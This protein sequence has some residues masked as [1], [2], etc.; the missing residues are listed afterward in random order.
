MWDRNKFGHSSQFLAGP[1]HSE[2]EKKYYE[3]N[4]QNLRQYKKYEENAKK[5]TQYF[6]DLKNFLQ[7]FQNGTNIFS[8]AQY[9]LISGVF[10]NIRNKQGL[11][12][13]N[14]F[15]H[16]E[17]GKAHYFEQQLADLQ[18]TLKS[19]VQQEN[20]DIDTIKQYKGKI[21][22]GQDKTEINFPIEEIIKDTTQTFL[23]QIG[24]KTKRYYSEQ[25]KKD[26]NQSAL[27]GFQRK[28]PK[29]DLQTDSVVIKEQVE[30]YNKNIADFAKLYSQ[31]TISAKNYTQ[32]VY[33]A[34][35]RESGFS[36]G[37]TKLFRILAD[38]IPTLSLG[39]TRE[40]E[41]SFQYA[42]FKRYNGL[43][44]NSIAA[45][46]SI[47]THFM[48]IQNIYE[49]T[50]IGQNYY[51]NGELNQLN[52]FLKQGVEYLIT[53]ISDSD[54]IQ[55]FSTRSILYQMYQNMLAENRTASFFNHFAPF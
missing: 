17:E 34:P 29:I 48:H 4:I 1:I 50:G 49:L 51:K 25:A 18:I 45:D 42:I 33:K 43:I 11:P 31:S 52:D 54:Y 55:V 24:V 15:R 40:Q 30:M 14:I 12:S 8:A 26:K 32:F 6:N 28:E 9:Q 13:T 39:L 7:N 22:I 16:K 47:Q 5:L 21:I 20:Y 23:K 27:I 35:W 36:I 19:I 41:I 10:E 37:N 44:K 3:K 2:V 38:F 46:S 53:N